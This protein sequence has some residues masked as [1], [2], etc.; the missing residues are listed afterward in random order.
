MR[1]QN[2]VQMCTNITGNSREVPWRLVIPNTEI[3]VPRLRLCAP[4]RQQ[5]SLASF[6]ETASRYTVVVHVQDRCNPAKPEVYPSLS[7]WRPHSAAITLQVFHQQLWRQSVPS[8]FSVS[9]PSV[10][11]HVSL[12]DGGAPH[13]PVLFGFWLV[14]L[15]RC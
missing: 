7:L 10:P 4:P 15:I 1:V 12:I 13:R 5:Y 2:D 6:G 8:F 14:L 9:F 11:L 3:V